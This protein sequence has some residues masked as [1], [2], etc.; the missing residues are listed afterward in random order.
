MNLSKMPDK[1]LLVDT[2]T[3]PTMRAR[4]PHAVIN[5]AS[6]HAIYSNSSELFVSVS[7]M[8]WSSS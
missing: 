1:R 4:P 6:C 8:C 2:D 3:A 5:D 7:F